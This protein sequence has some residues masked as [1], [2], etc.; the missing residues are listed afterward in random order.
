MLSLL[1]WPGGKSKAAKQIADYLPFHPQTLVSPFMGG[2]SVEFL[3]AQKGWKI[4]AYDSFHSLVCFWDYVKKHQYELAKILPRY[5]P[6]VNQEFRELQNKLITWDV[7]K[8]SSLE[9]AAVFYALNRASFSGSTL[10]GGMSPNHPRWTEKSIQNVKDFIG[11]SSVDIE[12]LDFRES[13]KRHKEEWL[14]L[15]PPYALEKNKNNL[16]GIKGDL[17]RH[18]P[19]E[20]LFDL[21]KDRNKWVMSYNDSEYIRNL[22]SGFKI[23]D[24]KWT[25]SMSKDKAS[26]EVIITSKDYGR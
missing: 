16:Y 10:S 3:L 14:Y 18:F 13:I 12:C 17:H 2:G 5:Y 4:K 15:D 26:K 21:I 9:V 1:R 11:M 7:D 25:Y 22:Y 24:I 20:E 19:H 6:M 23:Y 8:V